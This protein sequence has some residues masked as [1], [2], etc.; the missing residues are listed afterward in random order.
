MIPKREQILERARELYLQ[1]CV[2]NGIPEITP[3]DNELLENGFYAQA[4]SELMM[5]LDRK[6]EEFKDYVENFEDFSVNLKQL[7]ESNGLILGSRHCGKSDLAMQ[8]SDKAIEHDAIVCVFDPSTDWLARSSLKRYARI[9]ANTVLE[10]P[11]ESVIFD[12]SLLSPNQQRQIVENFSKTLFEHQA[13]A[14]NRRQYLIIFE[15]AHTYFYQNVMKAKASAN[16]V[17]MLS[18]GRN[19]SIATLL[20]SQFVSTLDKFCVKHAISQVWLGFTKEF[21]DLKYLRSLLGSNVEQLTKL[22]DG[23]FLYLTRN[24]IQKIAIEPYNSATPKTQISA[25]IP[26]PT[27]TPIAI[28]QNYNNTAMLNLIVAFMWFF[29]IV[30]AL[31]GRGF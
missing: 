5:S 20:I 12:I 21:N 13:K 26:E 9:E 4:K 2:R 22:N 8:I 30:L 17:R 1:Q 31:H 27:L 6:Y 14:L 23:E 7:F 11:S 10:V 16:S 24:G 29:A 19:V 18:V 25:K 3:E 28:K 15:E